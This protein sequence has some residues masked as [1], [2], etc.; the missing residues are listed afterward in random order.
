MRERVGGT[1]ER[2]GRGLSTYSW[3]FKAR[4]RRN[5]F[6]WRGSRLAVT[7]VREAVGEIAKVA[8]KDPALAAEGAVVFLERVSPALEQ[9]DS[10][11]GAIG[12]AVYRAIAAL[13]PVI[14]QAPGHGPTRD[15]W[16]ERL[17]A[18][19]MADEIPYIECL[20]DYWGDLCA[21]REVAS[22]WADRLMADTRRALAPERP[23][24]AFFKGTSACL[25]TLLAS[26]RFDE[27]M[28][29]LATETF[30]PYK[31]WSVKA[32][33]AQGRKA[34]AVRQ[35]EVCRSPWTND[36]AVDAMCEAILLSS[37][38]AEEAYRRYGLR[39]HTAGSYAATFRAVTKQYPDRVAREV[40][41]DLVGTTPGIEG[42]WFAAAKDAGFLEYAIALARRSPVDPKTLARAARDS[43]EAEPEFALEAGL[44]AIDGFANGLGFEVT[45]AD[46]AMA[47]SGA[48]KAG[49]KLGQSADVRQRVAEVLR[50]DGV[51]AAFVRQVLGGIVGL[52]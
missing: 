16:L 51:G 45:G 1:R 31:Q 22:R 2:R 48:M 9:V 29:L 32:L 30:W 21:S 12:S 36:R 7:R 25:S 43:A 28:Q 38:L 40:L 5:A 10:S 8:R 52:A 17:W 50:K 11:S 3:A 34:E 20:G 4:F 39:A 49:T 42:K 23:A 18:A 19:H 37:G 27:L 24:R 47:H 6:G 41:A 46:V 13:V 15:A 44:L 14:A 26:Q 35:A 33:L